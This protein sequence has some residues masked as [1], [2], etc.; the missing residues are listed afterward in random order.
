MCGIA[1]FINF[2]GAGV[3]DAQGIPVLRAMAHS[4]AHR[5][6]DDEQIHLWQNVGLAFRRLAIVD[7]VGGRQPLCNDDGSVALICNGEIFNHGAL[8]AGFRIEHC[9]RSQ[10]DCEVIVHLYERMGIR[11]L[12]HL[13]GIFAGA[14]LDKRHRKLFLF[15]D[16]LGVKPV[17]YYRNQAVFV[18]G[19]EVKAVLAHPDVPKRFDWSAA[20]T[21]RNRMHFPHPVGRL[22]SFFEEIRYLPAGHYL[23]IDLATGTHQAHGYWA[24]ESNTDQTIDDRDTAIRRYRELLEE[25]VD[26]QL[27]GDVGCGVFLSGGIDSV[28]VAY[29]AARHQPLDTFTVLSQST[30]TNGDAPAAHAA[31]QALHLP[32]HMV[33][34]DWRKLDIP[35]ALWRTILW[36]V[37]TPI[38]GAEQFY[39]YLLHAYARAHVPG[40]KVMLLGSGS[41]EFNGGYSQSVFNTAA[42][43][44]WETFEH[45]MRGYERESLLQIGGAWN[46]YAGVRAGNRMLIKQE[47]LAGLAGVHCCDT[48]WHVYRESYR[49]TLQTYQLWHEDRTAAAN[50]IE[51]RVPFLDH[52]L[53][54]LT[55]AISPTLYRDLFWDKTI[56]REAMRGLLPEGFHDRPK[57]P[58]FI[59][60]D[61]RYTRRLLYHMLCANRHALVEEALE[62]LAHTAGLIDAD[63]LWQLLQETPED[64]EFGNVDMLLDFVNMGL[65]SAMAKAPPEVVPWDG[66][67]P[68]T[69]IAIEDWSQWQE[70]C[71]Q[72]LVRRAPSLDRRSVLG[73]A[74]GIRVV[75]S[76]AGDP[77]VRGDGD[78]YILRNNDLEFALEPGLG[79]W[80]EFLRQ[81]DGERTV[82]EIL[83]AAGLAEQDIWKHLEEALEYEVLRVV[84]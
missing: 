67:L 8:R 51:A 34:F 45:V 31:A 3:P 66:A 16:R 64:P 52:R 58:F 17:Y 54:E 29:F 37:E 24:P 35:P 11:C 36:Q 61:L 6:P 78:F 46:G 33:L 60:E 26:M 15:R 69:A 65:L 38:A 9:L 30:L 76:E 83:Q 41:D 25:S 53:V 42:E 1:G 47:F 19:S 71:G 77:Q 4:I 62:E 73:F 81:V 39:K 10:S 75:K 12:E 23:E 49:R 21:Y 22:S 43:P 84:R 50:S 82:A 57:V 28:A 74:A 27:M 44:S 56:L 7:L 40:L 5:G 68:V 13:N 79:P 70:R 14:I 2:G 32:N 63:V 20:M 18:F 80:V 48:P 72:S 59:G 55:Y